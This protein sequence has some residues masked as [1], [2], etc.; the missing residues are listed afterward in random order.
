M[1]LAGSTKIKI[2]KD[3]ISYNVSRLEITEVILIHCHIINKDCQQ[4]SRVIPLLHI[5]PKNI[6]F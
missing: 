2:T 6:I 5:S 1:K 4:D 3:K